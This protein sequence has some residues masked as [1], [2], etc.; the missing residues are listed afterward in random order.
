[1]PEVT[2]VNTPEAFMVAFALLVDQVPP[3]VA[4]VKAGVVPPT[5]TVVAPPA[6]A[7]GA[8]LTVTL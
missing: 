3:A 1:M 7:A 2:P 6:I 5:Q 4:L 8:G